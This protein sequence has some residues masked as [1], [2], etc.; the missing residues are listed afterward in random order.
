LYPNPGND[1]ISI[2]FKNEIKSNTLF[3]IYNIS[4]ILID[5]F[6]ASEFN[7]GG[8]IIN[9]NFEPSLF[10]AGVYYFK[11]TDEKTSFIKEFIKF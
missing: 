6:Q 5:R 10:S 7:K 1:F 8:H 3:E 2:D 4:G 11:I 9:Y